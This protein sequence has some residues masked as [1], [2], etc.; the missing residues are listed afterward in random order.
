M[1]APPCKAVHAAWAPASC[2]SARAAWS[3]LALLLCSCGTHPGQPRIA[4]L[5]D[6]ARLLKGGSV[7]QHRE[8]L[9]REVAKQALAGDTAHMHP[10]I[11][12]FVKGPGHSQCAVLRCP[13]RAPLHLAS[14]LLTLAP[15][16]AALLAFSLAL[17]SG[18]KLLCSYQL[19]AAFPSG[20]RT[21]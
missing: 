1:A 13:A 14:L 17:R 2:G 9:E 16:H 4:C 3:S 21:C 15:G 5:Q 10:I 20:Y 8:V 6:L 7:E 12:L 18:R 19:E 11:G